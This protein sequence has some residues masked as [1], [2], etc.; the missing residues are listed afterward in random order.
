M[1]CIACCYWH[2]CCC[3]WGQTASTLHPQHQL[4]QAHRLRLAAGLLLLPLV[5]LPSK[6]PWLLGKS[7]SY[8]HT[9]I[10][11]SVRLYLSTY[12][13]TT[14]IQESSGLG[15]V[16]ACQRSFHRTPVGQVRG[17]SGTGPRSCGRRPH[18]SYTYPLQPA[19]AGRNSAGEEGQEEG[20]GGEDRGS[21]T[22]AAIDATQVSLVGEWM[23][24][25]SNQ[26]TNPS[27]PP[28]LA[29]IFFPP[30]LPTYIGPSRS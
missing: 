2:L 10:P 27:P 15:R 4:L 29:S 17:K 19:L 16:E 5:S 8:I 24:M 7:V 1:S 23:M 18:A 28:Y 12:Q 30:Y 21:A 26:P 25:M 6:P 14:Y 20:G 22:A 13:P 3:C 11:P 9:H